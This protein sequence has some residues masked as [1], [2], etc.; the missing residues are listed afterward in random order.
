MHVG[1]WWFGLVKLDKEEETG[2]ERERER[3]RRRRRRDL[4]FRI[5]LYPL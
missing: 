1:V 2:G 3:E 4:T 5:I